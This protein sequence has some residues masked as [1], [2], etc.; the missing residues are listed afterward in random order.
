MTLDAPPCLVSFWALLSQTSVTPNL[1]FGDWILFYAYL[2]LS[3]AFLYLS[4]LLSVLLQKLY[5][6]K[7][8]MQK[9]NPWSLAEVA[10]VD[11]LKKWFDHETISGIDVDKLYLWEM[12]KT[13]E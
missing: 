5:S 2:Q 10:S 12:M 4:I 9:L 11:H 8:D 1:L 13:S 7:L 3:Y 6:S